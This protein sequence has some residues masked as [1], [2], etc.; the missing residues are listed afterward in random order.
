MTLSLP[1]H[2]GNNKGKN[3]NRRALK[4]SAILLSLILGVAAPAWSQGTPPSGDAIRMMV[5]GFDLLQKGKVDQA[6]EFY[7]QVLNLDPGNPLALNNLG[8]I[9]VK[10]GNYQKALT[11]LEQAKAR[12]QGHKVFVSR[13]CD[14]EGVCLAYRPSL[15]QFGQEELAPL[16]EFNISMIKLMVTQGRR[17]TR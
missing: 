12:A 4:V 15:D 7:E 16:I 2:D 14:V 10:K 17:G 6:Q 5:Q 13:V 9:M 11:Y 3:M 8:A 1:G